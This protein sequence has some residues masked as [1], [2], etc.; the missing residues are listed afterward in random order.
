MGGRHTLGRKGV[1]KQV[2]SRIFLSC[3]A[4]DNAHS[5]ANEQ[6]YVFGLP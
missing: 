6:K 2:M 1:H 5:I 3:A 4:L